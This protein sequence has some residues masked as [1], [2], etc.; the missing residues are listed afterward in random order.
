MKNIKK[1]CQNELK[2]SL[3]SDKEIDE[4]AININM[5]IL[6]F[7]KTSVFKFLI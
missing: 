1:Y 6:E 2:K 4:I 7:K 3:E 5:Q